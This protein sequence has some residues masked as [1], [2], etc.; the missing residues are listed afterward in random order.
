MTDQMTPW[1]AALV[2]EKIAGMFHYDSDDRLALDSA[3]EHLRRPTTPEVVTGTE[4]ESAARIVLDHFGEWGGSTDHPMAHAL[5]VLRQV[6]EPV[7]PPA[8]G[9]IVTTAV[10]LD[11]LPPETVVRTR[12]NLIARR[13]FVGWAITGSPRTVTTQALSFPARIL[14]LPEGA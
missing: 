12:N 10:E 8:V 11:R 5:A 4:V 9:D 1:E 13:V 14:D 2:I 3:V 6:V 7:K